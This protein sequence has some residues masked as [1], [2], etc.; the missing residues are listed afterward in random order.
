M[1]KI[2]SACFLSALFL[3]TPRI[4]FMVA[5]GTAVPISEALLYKYTNEDKS[6]PPLPPMGS[7]GFTPASRYHHT[8]SVLQHAFRNSCNLYR[9]LAFCL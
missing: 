1:I 4:S 8:A 6:L 3:V 9:Q 5:W 7:A 2:N